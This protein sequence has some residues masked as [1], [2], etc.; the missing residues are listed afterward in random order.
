MKKYK[1][2]YQLNGEVII[3]EQNLIKAQYNADNVVPEGALILKV[4]EIVDKKYKLGEIFYRRVTHTIVR[5][6]MLIRGHENEVLLLGFP[7]DD[8]EHP[9][10]YNKYNKLSLT[11]KKE[12]Y[13]LREIEKAFGFNKG[14]FGESA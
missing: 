12:G 10:L 5:K 6:L 7:V 1:V 3:S 11:Y 8:A 13:T 14:D 9:C 2:Q 4:E